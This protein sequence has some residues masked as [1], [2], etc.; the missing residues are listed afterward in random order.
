MPEQGGQIMEGISG[1]ITEAGNVIKAIPATFTSLKDM[2]MI[3]I[4]VTLTMASWI[5]G[6][7]KGVL[8]FKKRGRRG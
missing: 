2:W 5:L 4:P 8:F 1:V 7:T 3:F 6:K